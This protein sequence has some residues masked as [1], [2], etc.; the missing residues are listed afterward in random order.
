MRV[1]SCTPMLQSQ[2]HRREKGPERFIAGFYG[3]GA[4]AENDGSYK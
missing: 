2:A 4:L 3:A 1:I